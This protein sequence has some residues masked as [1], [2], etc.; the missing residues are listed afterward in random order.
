MRLSGQ[1]NVDSLS[2]EYLFAENNDGRMPAL[3]RVRSSHDELGYETDHTPSI[4]RPA[5]CRES[6]LAMPLL[7][8]YTYSFTGVVMQDI[9][10]DKKGQD[11]PAGGGQG[12][13]QAA[14]SF[15]APKIR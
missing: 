14:R 10:V 12:D 8:S 4:W 2:I 15:T 3:R 11:S 5:S 13:A 7:R 6:C 1:C 9:V